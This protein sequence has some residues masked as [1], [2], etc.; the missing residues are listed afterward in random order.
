LRFYGW[1]RPS[2]SFGYFGRY[3]DVA[4]EA[5]H[6]DT[7]RRWTGGG[8][9]LH[10]DDLT[11]SLILPHSHIGA[12][13]SSRAIYSQVHGAIQRALSALGDV[14]LADADA[15]KVSDAC[16]ANPVVSDVLVSGRK[17]AGAAQRRTRAGL[18]H[19]GSIQYDRLPADFP[20]AFAAELCSR[21]HQ[22]VPPRALLDRAENIAAEKYATAEWLHRR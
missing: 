13:Q 8:V 3:S 15:P 18:L 20:P 5:V 4:N 21:F 11:Y 22:D 1:R 2:L 16:F 9:V 12:G 17:I 6:R 10:G 14:A 7:V 19:Q